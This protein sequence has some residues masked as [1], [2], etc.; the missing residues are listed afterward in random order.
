MQEPE[1]TLMPN[2]A[3]FQR[4]SVGYATGSGIV[5][6]GRIDEEG[7]TG[8]A[9][10]RTP[11]GVREGLL[12]SFDHFLRVDRLGEKWVAR[13]DAFFILGDGGG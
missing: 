5:R 1:S 7:A 11:L 4:R 12:D 2:S 8:G 13:N 6:V 10:P 9:K 3:I